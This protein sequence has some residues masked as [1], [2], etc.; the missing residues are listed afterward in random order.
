MALTR[1]FIHYE[2]T[3]IINE[4]TEEMNMSVTSNIRGLISGLKT[5]PNPRNFNR[6]NITKMT[7]TD[8][9]GTRYYGTRP[10]SLK[11]V[12]IGDK[13][14]FTA[15]INN[16]HRVPGWRWFTRPRMAVVIS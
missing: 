16:N 10:L 2:R 4:L 9:D 6:T 3:Y 8:R 1:K 15:E 11:S 13:V 14:E 5:T 7:V 12:E